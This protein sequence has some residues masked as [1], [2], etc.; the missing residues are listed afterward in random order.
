MKPKFNG[1]P[2]KPWRQV[3]AVFDIDGSSI[4]KAKRYAAYLFFALKIAK[5]YFDHRSVL[6]PKRNFELRSTRELR[7]K[8][9]GEQRQSDKQYD[10]GQPPPVC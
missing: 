4:G 10:W 8:I 3:D 7:P 2:V 9:R 1:N 6:G 5:P